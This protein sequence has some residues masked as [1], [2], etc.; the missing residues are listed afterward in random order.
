MAFPWG[1]VIALLLSAASIALSELLRPKPELEN[2]RPAGLGDFRF[3]TAIEGRAVPVIWGTI[4]LDGPNV[5]WYGNLVQ[6]PI[7]EKIKTGL[8]SSRRLTV[9]FR[10]FIS[11]DL[12]ICRGEV[13]AITGV[14]IGD[15]RVFD[16]VAVDGDP[17]TVA[18][19][20]LFGGDDLGNGGMVGNFRVFTGTALAVASTHIGQFVSPLPAYRGTCHLVWEGGLVGNSPQIKPWKFEVQRF[21]NQLGIPGG[22]EIVGMFDSNP[23][24]V[25]FEFLTNTDFGLS[26]PPA[27]IDTASFLAAA[28]T[29]HAEGN[30]F[31]FNLDRS[32]PTRSFL[33]EVERQ[34]DGVVLQDPLT[35]K[36]TIKLA[37]DDFDIDAVPEITID[38][39]IELSEFSRGTWEE[40]SNQVRIG[41]TDRSRDYFDTFAQAH[42]LANQRIQ[43]NQLVISNQKYPGVKNR[44]LA[45][46]IASRELLALSIPL[47]KATLVV[48]RTFWNV[49]RGDVLAWTDV[50]L[51]FTK[52]AV[53]VLRVDL[54]E[55]LDNRIT[56]M[57]VQ[58]IFQAVTAFFGEPDDT[59][60]V[61]PDTEA[62]GVP[63]DEQVV[64]EAPNALTRRDPDNP[65]NVPDRLWTGA[66]RPGGESIYKIFQRNALGVPSGSFVEDGEVYGFFLVGALRTALDGGEG[67]PTTL[68]EVDPGPDP[69]PDLLAEFTSPTSKTDIGQNLVNL[70]LIDGEFMGPETAADDTTHID[71]G[72][73]WRGML[74]SVPAAHAIGADV[75]LCFVAGGLSLSSIPPGNTVDV[76]LRTASFTG[77]VATEAESTTVTFDLDDRARRPY[78]PVELELNTVR[79][80]DPVNFDTVKSGGSGLDDRGIELDY[81]RRDFRTFDEVA[82]LQT[83]AAALDPT[84]PALNSTTY[85]AE[86][87][88]DPDGSPVSLFSTAFA[89]TANIFLGR[90]AILR[91]T[92]GVIPVKLR[93]EVTA[94]HVNEGLTLDSRVPLLW[95]FDLAAST[96]DDDTNLANLAQ[97][98]ISGIYTAP[99]SGTYVFNLGTALATGVVEARINGGGFVT[100]IAATATTGTLVGVVASDTI[101]VRHT[102]PASGIETFLEIDAPGSTLD[103]YAIL[104]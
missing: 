71:L 76:Q 103:A 79:F 81:L 82:G 22:K 92:A 16:G 9:G 13:A 56:I 68:V 52:L 19:P 78:P 101:E 66:R 85:S 89:D 33:E 64:I 28:E 5:I 37:R 61:R 51:G 60:W 7:R 49:R 26:I 30:G 10:Y 32:I 24:A 44:T 12:G 15:T 36:F 100:V 1:I 67:Q 104:I 6:Q 3:P 88:D 102:D 21:P 18:L 94:R 98:V 77:D 4:K 47:A 53:R 25:L 35:A 69:T 90:T 99:T 2:K 91:Q 93:V 55:L 45:T 11:V 73:V 63:A 40:T 50:E 31:S 74:D 70:I 72:T 41:F 54:G 42:D 17:I 97:N 95:D 80:D 20:D 38:N 34:I 65:S 29:L 86:I 84:F 27:D 39:T 8:F 62:A 96:L 43:E 75:F 59:L 58:D 87:T 23:A 14:W 46:D 48:D 57:F 83:D